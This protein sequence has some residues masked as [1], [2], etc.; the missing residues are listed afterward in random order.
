ML[1]LVIDDSRVARR[2]LSRHLEALGFSVTE[3]VDGRHALETVRGLRGLGLAVVDWNMPELDGLGFVQAFR[4]DPAHAAVK[5][6]M[7][8]SETGMDKVRQA[9]QAGADEYVMKPC[10]REM[11]QEKLAMLGLP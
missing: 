3:A 11:L 7:V 1:V 6:L 8:T 10:T 5:I 9:L 2:I 4:A